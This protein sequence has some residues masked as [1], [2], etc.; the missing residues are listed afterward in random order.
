[1][2]LMPVH[3]SQTCCHPVNIDLSQNIQTGDQ[4]G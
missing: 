3:T 2:E 4:E 1:M